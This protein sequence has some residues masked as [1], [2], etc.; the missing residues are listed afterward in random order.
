MNLSK[1][2]SHRFGA[3]FFFGFTILAHGSVSDAQLQKQYGGKVLTIRQFYPGYH[4]HFDATG[5][6]DSAVAPGAWTV[7]GQVQ[8]KTIVLKDG[9][10]HILGQRLLLFFDTES[11]QLRDV[12]SLT[13]KDTA[14]KRFSRKNVDEWAVEEGRIEIEVECGMTH[15]KKA[16]LIKAMNAVFLA[17]GEALAGVAPDF[18][19]SY[20]SEPKLGLRERW[21]RQISVEEGVSDVTGGFSLPVPAYQPEPPFSQQARQ[22]GY[23]AI[24]TL[25]LLVDQDGLPQH[26]QILQPA[27]MGLDENAVGAVRTWRFHPAQR[28]G[29]T[30]RAWIAVNVD[31]HL[32]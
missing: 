23:M 2:F 20:L 30:A 21:A 5:K 18:W 13:T 4:L 28:E 7:D 19:K 3:V 22:A 16:D 10:V 15:P 32:Y 25:G 8:V 31:F 11:K 12:G 14:M 9:V 17:P 1:N 29:K 6:L 27:G 26:I 24:T